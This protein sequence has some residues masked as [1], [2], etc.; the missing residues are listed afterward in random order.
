MPAAHPSEDRRN[1]STRQ[2]FTQRLADQSNADERIWESLKPLR[3]L[4]REL[5]PRMSRRRRQVLDL[6][7]FA[8][9]QPPKDCIG[10]GRGG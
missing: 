6:L 2:Q 9:A 5:H 7:D 1:L 8:R 3:E 10:Y 4:R